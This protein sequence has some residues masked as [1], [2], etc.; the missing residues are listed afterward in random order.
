[1]SADALK[2]GARAQV[3]AHTDTLRRSFCLAPLA[4]LA[5]FST[6]LLAVPAVT[7][8]AP[9]VSVRLETELGVIVIDLAARA[10]PITAENFLAYVDRG[11][12]KGASFYRTVSPANDHNP[13]TINLIQ[14]GLNVDS[15]PLPPI[16]HE[17]TRATGLR[18]REGTISMAR[19]EPGTAA[20]EFFICLGDNP[21]L[22]FGGARN[23]DGQGFAAFGQVSEGMDVVRR[24][25]A[26]PANAKTE[27]AYLK[28]QILEAPVRVLSVKRV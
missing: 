28:G 17:T 8:P 21:A 6:E 24:I 11:L 12:W 1:V 13:A 18:H 25:H 15:G 4:A 10:A 14:G 7:S 2:P 27:E 5:G 23:S 22:D 19:G 3:H 26:R 20:S 9:A 16:A